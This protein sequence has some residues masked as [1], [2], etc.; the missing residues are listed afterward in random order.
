M[1]S[2]NLFGVLASCLALIHGVG[3]SSFKPN[4]TLPPPDTNF[5]SGPNIR[6]T[7]TIL[8]NSLSIILLC[9]WNIQHLNIA[10]GRP[11]Y[12]SPGVQ[13]GFLQKKLWTFIDLGTK[14]KWMA[15]TILIPEYIMGRALNELLAAN[16]GL[17]TLRQYFR[18][19]F[20][21]VHAYVINMGGYYLD[22][23]DLLDEQKPTIDSAG[24]AKDGSET[25]ETSLEAADSKCSSTIAVL[26]EEAKKNYADDKVV[27]I[28]LDRMKHDRWTL[29]ISQFIRA[30][31]NGLLKE[32]PEIP[33]QELEKLSNGDALV[34][35]LAILQVL[36]L[37]VQLIERQV[38]S[39]PISQ[40]EI[41]VLAFA[42]SS[43]ITYVILFNHPR[44]FEFH[45]PVKATRLPKDAFKVGN[46]ARAG[47]RY[48]WTWNRPEGRLDGNHHVPLMPNDASHID[49]DAAYTT[50]FD[51]R[52]TSFLMKLLEKYLFASDGRALSVLVGSILGGAVFGG[53][54]CLAWNFEFPT[55]IESLLWKIC[56]ALTTGIP[57]LSAYPQFVWSDNNG[58]ILRPGS[59][60]ETTKFWDR[61]NR[62]VCSATLLVLLIVYLLARVYLMA[63]IFRSLFFLPPDAFISTGSGQFPHWS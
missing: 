55:P 25:T 9:T 49:E 12:K 50:G 47:P 19:E 54:H 28:N 60:D 3:A 22:F 30:A 51:E 21:L 2:I 52:E 39:L 23:S 7:T 43:L 15:I 53:I 14:I 46:I 17:F 37:V 5:V 26:V 11:Y 1:P 10:P 58:K 20:E 4:C 57:L 13:Y 44:G 41:A 56:A 8:F 33:P 32:L 62:K 59:V 36:S 31:S 34:K 18:Q 42:V 29:N 24:V 48:L 38:T 27:L 61:I 63:E 40:L 6:G 35:I 16:V 45:R